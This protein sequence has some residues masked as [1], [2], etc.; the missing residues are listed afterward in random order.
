MST[1][2]VNAAALAALIAVMG[3]ILYAVLAASWRVIHDDGRLRLAEMLRR[4]G[5]AP[6]QALGVGG[7][8]AAIAVRRCMMCAH[9]SECNQWLP[10]GA[11]GGMEAF[12]PNAEFVAR[13]SGPHRA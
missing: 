8:Q 2:G 10:S 7:Y 6:E 12:C 13:M 9:K 4:Q 5:A 11:K 1:F 3:L